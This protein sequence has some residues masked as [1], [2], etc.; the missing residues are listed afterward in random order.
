MKE[1]K[2]VGYAKKSLTGNALQVVLSVDALAEAERYTGKDGMEYIGLTMWGERI[3]EI[4]NGDREV[5][6]ITQLRG[7]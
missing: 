2:L 4:L 3:R 5:T 6:S 1:T 7:D